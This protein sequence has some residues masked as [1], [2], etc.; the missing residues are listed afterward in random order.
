[1]QGKSTFLNAVLGEVDLL[2]GQ[3]ELSDSSSKIAYCSQDAFLQTTASIRDNI[4]F[5][6]QMD[7]VWYH[8]VLEACAL[9]VDFATFENGDGRRAEDLSGGQKQRIVGDV[10]WYIVLIR[11]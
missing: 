10:Q 8:I 11:C 5:M 1:V 6:A 4:L 3:V 9:D 7:A 2:S